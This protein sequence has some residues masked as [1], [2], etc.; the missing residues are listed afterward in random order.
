MSTILKWLWNS[1]AAIFWCA[2][3]FGSPFWIFS[4]IMISESCGIT[5]YESF[6]SPDQQKEAVILIRNCGATTNWETQV[7]VRDSDDKDNQDLLIR[8]DGHPENLE[9]KVSWKS[10]D[11]LEVTEFNFKDLLS[12][13]SRNLTGDITKSVIRPKA[14]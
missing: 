14:S 13:H 1:G 6:I 5:E 10:S 4:L 9:Y 2:L 3:I 12:F 11:L 7:V 8:L